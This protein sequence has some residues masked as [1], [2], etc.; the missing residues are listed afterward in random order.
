MMQHIATATCCD[1]HSNECWILYISQKED[2]KSGIKFKQAHTFLLKDQIL[3]HSIFTT[4]REE[5]WK[6][7]TKL[8]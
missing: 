8:I 3:S 2:I 7:T 1:K 5:P 4:D 6:K